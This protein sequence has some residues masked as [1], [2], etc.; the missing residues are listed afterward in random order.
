MRII[1]CFPRDL[2]FKEDCCD[3]LDFHADVFVQIDVLRR[4]ICNL[5]CF[6]K[7]G[8]FIVGN[9]SLWTSNFAF[10]R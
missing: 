7:N 5:K 2:L 3:G 6:V 8:Y 1:K 9:L 4:L 10:S